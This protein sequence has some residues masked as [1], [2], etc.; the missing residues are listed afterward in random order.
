[1]KVNLEYY[2]AFYHVARE[3]SL[4]LA[5]QVM[6]VTQP[7]LSKTII[8]LEKQLGSPLF[9]RSRKGMLLTSEGKILYRYITEAFEQIFLGEKT[10]DSLL[11]FGSGEIHVGSS[12]IILKNYLLPNL[13][14]FH[15]KYPKIKLRTHIIT[16]SDSGPMLRDGQIDFAIVTSPVSQSAD[17]TCHTVGK[18]HDIFVCGHAFNHL[19]DKTLSLEEIVTLPL[20]CP[21]R[22]TG[23]RQFC[24]HF[25]R[26]HS[27]L[28]NPEFELATTMLVPSFVSS[29]LGEGLVMREFVQEELA[30]GELFELKMTQ[31]LPPRELSIITKTGTPLS[32]ACKALLS[33]LNH[34]LPK[35]F[36]PED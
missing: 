21:I 28:I 31:H 23:Q 34:A 33:K 7:S 12:D 20:I 3:G 35:A 19:R 36:D 29:G 26:S 30:S 10:L 15:I 8:Q 13:V 2:R 16:V 32:H 6:C 9:I 14:K 22:K 25:F 27:L 4:T 1:M 5:A 11:N 24:D 17:L 18:V